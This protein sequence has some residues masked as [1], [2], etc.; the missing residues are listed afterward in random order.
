MIWPQEASWAETALSG[1]LLLRLV[2]QSSLVSNDE[3]RNVCKGW[4]LFN[5]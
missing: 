3:N 4:V 5:G 2:M 1:K